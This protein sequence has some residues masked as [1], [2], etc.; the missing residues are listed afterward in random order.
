METQASMMEKLI[1]KAEDD[2]DFRKKLLEDPHSTLSETFSIQI[3]DDFK[4]L[5]L[6]DDART[7]H[8]VLPSIKEL[9]DIELQK[10]A[11]GWECP[12]GDWW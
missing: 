6:E 1:A 4:V 11:G 5:V 2:S 12:F 10:A 3:P 7:A 9:S 8:I